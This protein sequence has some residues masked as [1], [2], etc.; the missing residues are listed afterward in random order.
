M[1]GAAKPSSH[2]PHLATLLAAHKVSLVL[3]VGAN[4]GQYG[5]RLIEHGYAGRIVSYEPLAAA[6]AT[7][8]AKAAAQPNWQVAPR[9]AVGA[10]SGEVEINVSAESDMSSILAMTD[11]AQRLFTSSRAVGRESV[12]MVT[13]AGE[14]AARA[15]AG[16]RIF[17]KSDTQGFESAVLDGLGGAIDRVIGLQLELALHPVYQ[18]QPR[19]LELLQRVEAAGFMPMLVIPGYWSR[20]HGRMLEFDLVAFRAPN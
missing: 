9:A 12:P 20:H 1:A 10:S 11:E 5:G 18:G 7:L 6:H 16:E 14:I 8:Q 19:Y 3:D 2:W 4:I 17:V 13:L 15:V